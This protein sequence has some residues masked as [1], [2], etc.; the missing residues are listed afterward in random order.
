M[1]Q[2]NCVGINWCKTHFNLLT[3]SI[4]YKTIAIPILW[5]NLAKGGNSHTDHRMYLLIKA[6]SCIGK[7]RI[8]CLLAGREFIGREWFEWLTKSGIHIAIRLRG[9]MLAKQS[10]IDVHPRPVKS[11]FRRLK[12]TKKKHLKQTYLLDNLSVYLCASWS[13]SGELLNLA[14]PKPDRYALAR[15]RHRWEIE[16][17]FGC[18]KS[19]GFNLEDTHITDQHKVERLLFIAVIAFY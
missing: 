8:E 16:N 13:L 19:R 11:L 3:L 4:V 18:L 2:A 10:K 7:H 1:P 5:M 9:N 17:L 15:Y 12:C 6:I 14:S